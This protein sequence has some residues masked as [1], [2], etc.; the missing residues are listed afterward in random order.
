MNRIAVEAQRGSGMNQPFLRDASAD[1]KAMHQLDGSLFEYSGP[2]PAFD[3]F[4][5]ALL[6]HHDVD[7]R[8]MQDV[9]EEQ[10]GWPGADDSHLYPHASSPQMHLKTRHRANSM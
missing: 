8:R 10:P 4:A 6:E 3:V 1:S 2:H 9:R 5:A 7:T